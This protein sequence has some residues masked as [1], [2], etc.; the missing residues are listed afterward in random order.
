MMGEQL[1]MLLLS[2]LGLV[3]TVV[4]VVKK[5]RSSSPV[6]VPSSDGEVV[7]AIVARPFR[8]GRALLVSL[9]AVLAVVLVSMS[10]VTIPASHFGVVTLWGE[11]TQTV[12]G[13]GL[14]LVNPFAK[15]HRISVGL[16]TAKTENNEA[17]SR[18]LQT[19]HTSI[20]V[21]YRVNP[22]EVRAL[23]VQNPNLLYQDQYVVPA[24]KEILKS[25]TSH[26]TAEEL[27]TKRSEVSGKIRD[28]LATKLN[29]YHLLVQDINITNF[30]FSKTFNESIEN[31]VRATQEAERAQRDLERVKFEAEQKIVTARAS[32]QAIRIQA[33]AIHSQG[34]A[35]FV[36]LEAIKKW[37][38]K[39]PT[40]TGAGP[41]PIL[42]LSGK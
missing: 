11:V 20:T 39:L 4:F 13:E 29:G 5:R 6:D 25:V 28:Q 8:W 35:A 32:A 19:V 36:Q 26:Y 34:G 2:L 10:V 30:D 3:F 33:E 21:N 31:K 23:Y 18:D 14:H 12:L 27:V 41:V 9:V 24:I 15:V 1:I 16:D 42:N 40:Y 38:G 37:D 7:P 22:A 17:A